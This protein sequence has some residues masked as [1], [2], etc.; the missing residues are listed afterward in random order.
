MTKSNAIGFYGTVQAAE[1]LGMSLPALKYHIYKGHIQ[2]RKIGHS[3][4]FTQAQLDEFNRTRRPPG[5]PRTTQE[6]IIT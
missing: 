2:Y 1:H 6:S 5:R 3:L 4:I